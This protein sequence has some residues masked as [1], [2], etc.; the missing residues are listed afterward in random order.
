MTSMTFL[1][2]KFYLHTAGDEF[3]RIIPTNSPMSQIS[4]P[5]Y[6]EDVMPH[7]TKQAKLLNGDTEEMIVTSIY[8]APVTKERR[9]YMNSDPYAELQHPGR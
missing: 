8:S 7:Q 1:G 9:P 4:H 6:A 2:E 5:T 3:D